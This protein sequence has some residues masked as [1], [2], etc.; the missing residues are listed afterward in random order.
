MSE[1]EREMMTLRL[2]S[3]TDQRV[4]KMFVIFCTCDRVKEGDCF[5][6]VLT[7]IM[8][9]ASI[10]EVLSEIPNCCFGIRLQ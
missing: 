3:N 1:L 7:T 6:S 9:T 8:R 4:N 10:P 2:S 5:Y